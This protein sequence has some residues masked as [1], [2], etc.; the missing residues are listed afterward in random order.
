MSTRLEGIEQI[1]NAVD[2]L[3]QI[4]WNFRDRREGLV[5]GG[6]PLLNTAIDTDDGNPV[7]RERARRALARWIERLEAIAAEG[8]EKG[9]VGADVDTR[10]VAMLIVSGL[11]GGLMMS[12]LQKKDEAVKLACRHLE[13]YLE[14]KARAGASEATKRGENS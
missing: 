10:E 7:L 14:T 13:D 5:P 12:R 1:A 6:C 4:V 8:L 2:R 3:K 11:E 9:E